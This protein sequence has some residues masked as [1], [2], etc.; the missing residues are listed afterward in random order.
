M[1]PFLPI[2]LCLILSA[3]Q[4]AVPTAKVPASDPLQ[5]QG[6]FM[7]P[8]NKEWFLQA[9]FHFKPGAA[10]SLNLAARVTNWEDV[11]GGLALAPAYFMLVGADGKTRY[12]P[13][14]TLKAD[15]QHDLR[16]AAGRLLSPQLQLPSDITD[17]WIRED[18]LVQI[19]RPAGTAIEEIGVINVA[20]FAKP[21][22]LQR[23][24]D[25]LFQATA[26]AGEPKVSRP[27]IEGFG[28]IQVLAAP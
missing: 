7:A 24:A 26:A 21:A 19:K 6:T 15:A 13:S 18:G 11:S 17:L 10:I 20:G 25:G 2:A 27:T 8:Q 22:A 9:L 16:D 5:P 1:R 28:A 12:A 4:A 23:D 3:C 14:V